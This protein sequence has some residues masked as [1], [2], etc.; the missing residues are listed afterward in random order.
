MK[1]PTE[2][3]ILTAAIASL[4]P[5]NAAPSTF[6]CHLLSVCHTIVSL[7]LAGSGQCSGQR[8]LVPSHLQQSTHANNTDTCKVLLCCCTHIRSTKICNKRLQKNDGIVRLQVAVRLSMYALAH[9]LHLQHQPMSMLCCHSLCMSPADEQPQ[10]VGP[11]LE[12]YHHWQPH[13]QALRAKEW[14]R[15]SLGPER[16]A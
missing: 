1:G 7:N 13:D 4:K 2:D 16:I 9:T 10:L 6:N 12:P 5:V 3:C 8:S 14:P 11:V 15:S